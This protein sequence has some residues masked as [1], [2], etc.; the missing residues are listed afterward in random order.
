LTA[1][2]AGQVLRLH[3][4]VEQPAILYVAEK[5]M[6]S[7]YPVACGLLRGAQILQ[8]N[9]ITPPTHTAET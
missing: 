4:P 8:R 9:S 6:F 5:E 1:L 2:Q 7:V 3:Q